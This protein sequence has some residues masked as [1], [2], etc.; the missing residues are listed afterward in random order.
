MSEGAQEQPE[1]PAEAPVEVQEAGDAAGEQDAVADGQQQDGQPPMTKSQL[2]KLKKRQYF[3]E[4]K[5]KRRETER[6]RKQEEQARRRE[7]GR[8]RMAAMTEEEQAKWR[9]ERNARGQARKQERQEAKARMEKALESGQKVVIDLDFADLM[10]E[11]ERK[12]I[13]GQLAYSWHANCAA[14]HPL[15]LVLTSVQG[16]MKAVLDKQV[17]GY[18]NWKATITEKPYIEHFAGEKGRLVYLT[19]DSEHELQELDGEAVYIIGGI[20]DRNRHK[21]LCYNKAEEQGIRHARLPVGD[22][23][24][25]ASSQVMTTNHVVEI[26]LRWLELRDWKRAFEAVIPPRKRKAEDGEQEE[27]EDEQP[28]QKQQKQGSDAAQEQQAACGGGDA[29][30]QQQAEA[31]PEAEQQQEQEQQAAAAEAAAAAGEQA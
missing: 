24:K 28:Q 17:S 27:E 4:R 18:K 6:Q 16:T 10:R 8:Q 2:K 12:S 30:E 9:E 7:E 3:E 13:C 25:L 29:G 22:Y 1:A 31:A 23:M 19:A 21:L 14:Q 5:L 11:P 15:H 20:V 26:M